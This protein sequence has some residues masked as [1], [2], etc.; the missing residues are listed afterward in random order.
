M[1]LQ[2]YGFRGA[3]QNVA[4][5]AHVSTNVERIGYQWDARVEE[6]FI[7]NAQG[8]EH[9]FTIAERPLD[10]MPAARAWAW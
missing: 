6:W 7:N 3:E 1:Q 5:Q 4:K 8:L 9:G 10:E 2:S